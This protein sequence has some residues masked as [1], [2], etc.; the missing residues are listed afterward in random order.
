MGL[1]ATLYIAHALLIRL[2]G[3]G[4]SAVWLAVLVLPGALAAHLARKAAGRY[5]AEREGLRAGVLMAHFAAI[6]Q[7][8]VLVIGVLSVD[9]AAYS[10]QVGTDIGNGVRDSAPAATTVATAALVAITYAGCVAASWMG[11]VVY[12]RILG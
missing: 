4:L 8:I 12:R 7:V 1:V 11:A 5:D 9:W 6:L 10:A 3:Q 2:N